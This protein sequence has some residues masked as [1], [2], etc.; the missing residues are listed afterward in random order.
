MTAAAVALRAASFEPVEV[1][2]RDGLQNE[3]R[4]LDWAVRVELIDRLLAAGLRRV[5]AGSFVRADVIP[6]M[7]DAAKVFAGVHRTAGARLS[8]L[9]L[10]RRGMEAAV[11]AGA[12][13][14]NVVVPATET[15][16]QRNQ[17]RSIAEL[18]EVADLVAATA[19]GAG[20]SSTMT[21]AVAFGCPY[22]GQVG[23]EAV[24]PLVARAHAAGFDELAFAD[25]IG[26]GV[27]AQVAQLAAMARAQAPGTALRFH[28]H[29][30]RNTGY[31][32]ALAALTAGADA[33][34]AAVGG[35]G[36]CAFAPGSSGNIATDELVYVL[37][38]DALA[39]S[40]DLDALVA[41]GVWLAGALGRDAPSSLPRVPAF[42]PTFS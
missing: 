3:A 25:T 28:F 20:S 4:T 38:A 24:A 9:V 29:N 17:R 39:P 30:T 35:F 10:N 14:L 40:V 15:L 6:Q 18:L 2:P 19:R 21:I 37:G 12:D 41:T 16:A 31:A 34:D 13:E 7:A 23:L 26:V 32:N 27:P 1:G 11:E 22:E 33:L 5:E 36:G 42:P 8:A